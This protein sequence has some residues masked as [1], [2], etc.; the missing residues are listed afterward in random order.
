M[1]S[2]EKPKNKFFC[3]N[4]LAQEILAD[5]EVNTDLRMLMLTASKKMEK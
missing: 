5:S 3:E 1:Q 4:S 2:V